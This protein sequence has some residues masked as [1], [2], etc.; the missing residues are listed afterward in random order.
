LEHAES[1]NRKEKILKKSKEKFFL[2][3]KK[4]YFFSEFLFS[5]Q[6]DLKP[7]KTFPTPKKAYT[8]DF[9][10]KK[11]KIK[12]IRIFAAAGFEPTPCVTCH[13]CA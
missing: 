11:P 10:R 8:N 1:E 4:Y 3:K 9:F 13:L 2:S 6:M 12:P 7:L 5:S